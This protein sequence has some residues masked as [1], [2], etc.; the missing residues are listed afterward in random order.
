MVR[1]LHTADLHRGAPSAHPIY[2]NRVIPELVNLAS[3]KKCAYI[4]VVG[5]IFDKAKPDQIIK[6]QLVRQLLDIPR[7]INLIFVPGNHDYTTKSLEYHSLHYLSYIREASNYKIN[8]HI[9]EPGEYRAFKEMDL[10]AMPDWSS[11]DLAVKERN[12]TKPLILAWHGLVPNMQF[13]NLTHVPKQVVQS[14]KKIL[15][16]TNSQYIAL[17]DIHQPIRLHKRCWYPGPPMQ[18]T[19]ADIDNVLCV[20]LGMHHI[21]VKQCTLPL[22]KKLTLAVTFDEGKDSEESI[23]DFV[24]NNTPEKNFVKLKFELP[25]KVWGTLN[26]TYIKTA[27]Q[28]HCLEIK[29]EN[30]PIP[31]THVRKSIDKISRADSL[32]QEFEIIMN[33]EHFGLDKDNLRK[34][35]RRYL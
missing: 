11:I 18:K 20:T 28:D 32:Q 15:T 33:E 17:G 10:F 21:K 2:S 4:I 25:L 22:P 8:I 31:E 3:I 27:L 19:Y 7:H 12:R 23:I 13:T 16:E 5:D 9:V 34:I 30:D 1:I 24:R 35:S 29:L 26:R 6:D 14:I